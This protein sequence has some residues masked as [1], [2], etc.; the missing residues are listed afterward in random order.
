MR[1]KEMKKE[2]IESRKK[3]KK[4]INATNN[5]IPAN[6]LESRTK[7][8]EKKSEKCVLLLLCVFLPKMDKQMQKEKIVK[9]GSYTDP[10]T[11]VFFWLRFKKTSKTIRS[12]LWMFIMTH[13]VKWHRPSSSSSALILFSTH[14]WWLKRWMQKMDRTKWPKPSWKTLSVHRI[15]MGQ[16]PFFSFFFSIFTN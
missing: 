7:R 9:N 16:V 8:K 12:I 4:N 3:G 10:H 15:D 11:H 6:R 5:G 13:V 2:T 14:P 1:Y